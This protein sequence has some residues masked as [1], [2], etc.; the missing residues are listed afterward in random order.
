MDAFTLAGGP[1][2]SEKFLSFIA[3][4]KNMKVLR[5]IMVLHIIDRIMFCG[6]ERKNV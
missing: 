4:G 5:S 3:G 1:L 6:K 2:I